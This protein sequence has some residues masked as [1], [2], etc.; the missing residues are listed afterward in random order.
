MFSKSFTAALLAA[1]PA[2]A[3]VTHEMLDSVPTGWEH[4]AEPSADQTV[5]L[6]VA[7]NL[8]NID[9]MVQMLVRRHCSHMAKPKLNIIVRCFN[10]GRS[11]LRK[12]LGP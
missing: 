10:T 2:F 5:H 11:I 7:L 3:H 1:V 4:I 12:A 6:E 8:N 9:K